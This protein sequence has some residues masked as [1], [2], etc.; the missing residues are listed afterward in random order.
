MFHNTFDIFLSNRITS[1]GTLAIFQ[2]T[3][4]CFF[5]AIQKTL[6]QCFASKIQN[7]YF[8]LNLFREDWVTQKSVS[9]CKQIFFSL[10]VQLYVNNKQFNICVCQRKKNFI[11]HA[12]LITCGLFMQY[13]TSSIESHP[14]FRN[15]SSNLQLSLVF[16]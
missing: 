15:L 14:F 10:T 7:K 12:N 1:I 8:G 11:I 3:F 9:I 6:V 13:C 5:Q 2:T 16:L 4:E